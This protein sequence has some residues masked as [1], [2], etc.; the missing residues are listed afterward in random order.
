VSLTAGTFTGGNAITFTFGTVTN[1]TTAQTPT[2]LKVVTQDNAGIVLG[3]SAA[4]TCQA[5]T[6]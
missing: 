5:I 3:F 2:N 6:T 1:P 4:G